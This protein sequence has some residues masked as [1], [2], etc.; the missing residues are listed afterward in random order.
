MTAEAKRA[1]KRILRRRKVEG[2]TGK[3]RS[4]IYKG[5]QDGTFPAPIRLGPRSVGWLESDIDDWIAKCIEN[6]KTQPAARVEETPND[7]EERS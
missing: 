7:A 5:I 1:A 2:R 4:S 6:S 3:S